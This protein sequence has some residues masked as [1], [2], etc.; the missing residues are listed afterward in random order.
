VPEAAAAPAVDVA[1]PYRLPP[2]A[3]PSRYDLELEPDLSAFTFRGACAT[4][5]SLA[6][7]TDVLVCNA[8]E[9][10]IQAA[11][12]TCADGSRVET[13]A[14]ETD[15]ET[16]RLMLRLARPLAAGACVL[17]TEFTGLLNDKLHGFYRSTFTDDQGSERVIAT[18]QFEATDARRAFPCWDEPEHKAVF[19]ITLVVDPDL[20]AISNAAETRRTTR[21]DGKVVVSFADTIAMST[22]LVA[23]IVGPLEVT[24]PVDVDGTPLRV[25]YPRGKGHLTGYA[26]EVGAFCLR[27]FAEYFGLPYAGDKVDLVAVPDFAFGAMENLGCVTFREALV[28]V[29]PTEVTQPELQNVTDVIAHELAHMWFGDLVTMKWWNGIWLNEAFATFMEMLATDAF[30]PEWDRWVAFGLSRTVAFDTDALGTTRPIEFPVVSPADAEGMFDVLTY[31]KGAAVV[32]MLEQYLGADVFRQGIRGYMQAHQYANTE[33]TDLWDA[34]EAVTDE[35]VRAIMDSWIFQ[36]GHPLIRAELVHDEFGEAPAQLRLRQQRFGYA[37]SI[38]EGDP[39]EQERAAHWAAPVI[40]SQSSHDV[41]TFEKVLLD[42]DEMQVELIDPVDWVLVNTEGTGFYRVAYERDLREALVARAQDDLS[43]IE[44]YGLVDDAWAA[45]LADQLSAVEFLE[46]ARQFGAEDDVSV[47]RRLIGGLGVIDRLVDGDARDAL[48]AQVIELVGPELERLGREPRPDDTDRDR[49]R[50]GVLL[51]AAGV[52]GADPDIEV[53]ARGVLAAA[54]DGS[55]DPSLL[56]AAIDIV[57]DQGRPED[58]DRFLARFKSASTPQEKLRY[59]YALAGFDQAELVDRLVAICL[60]DE[61]RS[62]NAPYVLGR[63]MG[64]RQHGPRAWAFVRDHW[65]EV[66]ERF[67]SNSIVRMLG[68]L[69]SLWSA[70]VADDVYAFFEDHEVPQGDKQ[71]AQ[72]LERLEVNVALA[73]RATDDLSHH[74]HPRE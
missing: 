52:L 31:E 65:D 66:N 55:V 68:G 69:R 46:M 3:R 42:A 74:L 36:G 5:L 22:Y 13:T 20:A 54:D 61:I 49:E 57:A 4:A 71:L 27:F 18:T 26:L 11:W 50:R 53:F 9:L 25:V 24:D 34:I 67:P 30:K 72:H 28:L 32:R 10:E 14:I 23:F 41:V 63:A 60:T 12:V 51:A 29:E 40:L 21:A 58:F 48:A 2:T 7:P 35:P 8:I 15:T 37:G 70:P 19:A 1:D 59:L 43:P 64:N 33:T 62:Q 17:H 39:A 6:I 56:A 38:G 47:W 73:A 44:R 16:E 45:V